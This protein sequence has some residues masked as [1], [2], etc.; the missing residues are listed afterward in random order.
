MAVAV[1]PSSLKLSFPAF[2][3]PVA[4]SCMVTEMSPYAPQV[5]DAMAACNAKAQAGTP[6]ITVYKQALKVLANANIS[7]A[8]E[9]IHTDYIIVHKRNRGKL[10]MPL[11]LIATFLT[12]PSAVRRWKSCTVQRAS[13]YR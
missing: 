8:M 10:S 6:V 3:S 7:Y 13:R 4:S 11:T 5:M 9:E 2:R 12:S 1:S